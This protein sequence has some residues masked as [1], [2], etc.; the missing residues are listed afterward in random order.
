MTPHIF[1]TSW[2]II[3]PSADVEMKEK[4]TD[5]TLTLRCMVGWEVG[6]LCEPVKEKVF[7][8]AFFFGIKLFFF[9]SRNHNLRCS[10]SSHPGSTH[11]I[12]SL[13]VK[14]SLIQT[15]LKFVLC[16]T[17]WRI[18][19]PHIPTSSSEFPTHLLSHS[20]SPLAIFFF[21]PVH[22]TS[23]CLTQNLQR[24]MNPLQLATPLQQSTD[25]PLMHKPK[26]L[27]YLRPG[28]RRLKSFLQILWPVLKPQRKEYFRFQKENHLKMLFVTILIKHGLSYCRNAYPMG[29]RTPLPGE[30]QNPV[31]SIYRKGGSC[32]SQKFLQLMAWSTQKAEAGQRQQRKVSSKPAEIRFRGGVWFWGLKQVLEEDHRQGLLWRLLRRQAGPADTLWF[33]CGKLLDW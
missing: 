29:A 8:Q 33:H 16:C 26:G 14:F 10:C 30:G 1:N 12:L 15:T 13:L 6:C 32:R 7:G 23:S 24:T 3:Y 27:V 2:M 31:W 9:G 18:V 21:L 20:P 19:C 5:K 25:L 17:E 22:S 28:Q 11:N 4:I